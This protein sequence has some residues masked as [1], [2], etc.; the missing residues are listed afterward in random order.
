[1]NFLLQ[2]F[3]ALI[4]SGMPFQAAL[5]TVIAIGMALGIVVGFALGRMVR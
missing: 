5:A 2:I 4:G 3:D 1:M